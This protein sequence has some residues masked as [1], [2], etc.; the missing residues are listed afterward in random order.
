MSTNVVMVLLY[1]CKYV[2]YCIIMPVF[3]VFGC[4][5]LLRE[6]ECGI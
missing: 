3:V 5:I 1:A 2:M 4:C 6:E